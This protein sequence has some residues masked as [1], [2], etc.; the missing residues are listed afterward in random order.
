MAATD[1]YFLVC[2]SRP[3]TF[4]FRDKFQRELENGLLPSY[5]LRAIVAST[6]HLLLDPWFDNKQL[7][8]TQTMAQLAWIE[9]LNEAMSGISLNTVAILQ[10]MGLLILLDLR[11]K[12]SF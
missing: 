1:A 3:C 2:H 8:A 10:T 7:E 9:A 6:T 11:S 12:F 5:L 4:F